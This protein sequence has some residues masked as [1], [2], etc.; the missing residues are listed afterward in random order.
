MGFEVFTLRKSEPVLYVSQA[1]KDFFRFIL[2]Y[3]KENEGKN[4]Y[5]VGS[6]RDFDEYLASSGLIELTS[7]HTQTIEEFGKK[8]FYFLDLSYKHLDKYDLISPI[9]RTLVFDYPQIIHI[10]TDFYTDNKSSFT[11]K[12]KFIGTMSECYLRELDKYK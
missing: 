9:L 7:R 5:Y 4:Y 11:P 2:Q 12:G 6:E 10:T 8:D 1:K 3:I